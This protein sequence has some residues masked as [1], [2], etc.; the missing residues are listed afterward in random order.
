MPTPR[1]FTLIELAAVVACL[2]LG[3]IMLN[4]LQPEGGLLKARSTAR[5]LKDS[6]QQRGIHQ[7]FVLW[8]QNNNDEYPLPA[9]IDKR[10]DTVKEKGR[11]KNTSANIMSVL[12]YNGF[13]SPELCV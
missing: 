2:G 13:F 9:K 1:A 11:A 10:N 7:G 8:A 3:G 5:Q 6:T 4:P 12:I